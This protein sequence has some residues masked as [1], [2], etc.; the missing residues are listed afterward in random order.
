[1]KPIS[2]G[3]VSLA[4]T[5]YADAHAPWP[6]QRWLHRKLALAYAKGAADAI[7]MQQATANT[8]ALQ[9]A[10]SNRRPFQPGDPIT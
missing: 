7:S 5:L 4:A 9:Q 10:L 8:V 1:M 6:W 2:R 3:D